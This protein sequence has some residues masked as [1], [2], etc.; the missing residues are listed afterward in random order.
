[1]PF[2]VFILI[3]GENYHHDILATIFFRD[4]QL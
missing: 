4:V 3:L 1:M 2:F